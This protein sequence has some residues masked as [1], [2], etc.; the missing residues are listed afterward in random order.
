MPGKV[1]RVAQASEP[2]LRSRTYWVALGTPIHRTAM[3]VEELGL[4][5]MNGGASG[6]DGAMPRTLTSSNA[7]QSKAGPLCMT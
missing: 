5:M 1:P 7:Q 4:E 6:G 2:R 3:E